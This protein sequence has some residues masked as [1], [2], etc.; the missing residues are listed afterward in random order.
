MWTVS[1]GFFPVIKGLQ[2]SSRDYL[3]VVSRVMM[4]AMRKGRDEE[5]R[6]SPGESV[7][8]MIMVR[9]CDTSRHKI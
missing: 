7:M 2:K 3:S 9:S 4:E 1:E 5:R 8:L 6:K